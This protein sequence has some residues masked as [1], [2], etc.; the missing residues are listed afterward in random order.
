MRAYPSLHFGFHWLLVRL[1]SAFRCFHHFYSDV[2]PRLVLISALTSA[3][4]RL[5]RT[6]IQLVPISALTSANIRLLRTPIK[7]VPISAL[8]SASV[9]V[10]FG[11]QSNWFLFQPS[12]RPASLSTA[13]SNPTGSYFSPRLG[14]HTCLLRS[15]IQQLHLTPLLTPV[16]TFLATINEV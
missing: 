4:I 12:P 6:P 10:Y 15:P 16:V 2:L 11:L 5:L 7:L 9:P 8:T 13:D 14:Q 3:N 1:C